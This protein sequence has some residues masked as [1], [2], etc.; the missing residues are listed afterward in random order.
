VDEDDDMPELAEEAESSDDETYVDEDIED[1]EL[2]YDESDDDESTGEIQDV[3]SPQQE[4]QE[5]RSGRQVRPPARY[6]DT[7]HVS[8]A[9]MHFTVSS[10]HIS[11]A[12]TDLTMP[13]PEHQSKIKVLRVIMTQLSLREGL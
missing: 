12:A 3:P 7:T 11:V 9:G 1:I 10:M 8:V 4:V 2:V 5:T 13:I 6:R